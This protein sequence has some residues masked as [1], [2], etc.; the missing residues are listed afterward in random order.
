MLRIDL[1]QCLICVIVQALWAAGEGRHLGPDR[2]HYKEHQ[3]TESFRLARLSSQSRDVNLVHPWWVWICRL[4]PDCPPPPRAAPATKA[5]FLTTSHHA[6]QHHFLLPTPFF[7]GELGQTRLGSSPDHVQTRCIVFLL[8]PTGRSLLYLVLRQHR[9]Q[10]PL[11]CLGC[12]S[13]L[14]LT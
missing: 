14:S 5:V 10:K 2:V 8:Q 12:S 6:T 7:L 4:L 3:D 11:L 9:L 13:V 1:A